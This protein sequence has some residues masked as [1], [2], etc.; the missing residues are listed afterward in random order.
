MKETP[1]VYLAGTFRREDN[2]PID[3]KEKLNK[4]AEILQMQSGTGHTKK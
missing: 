3:I 1:W 4:R 2:K